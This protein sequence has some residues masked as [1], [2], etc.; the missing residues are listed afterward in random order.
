MKKHNSSE[1]VRKTNKENEIIVDLWDLTS[2]GISNKNIN[3]SNKY[4]IT[5]SITS[6]SNTKQHHQHPIKRTKSVD[7]SNQTKYHSNINTTVPNSNNNNNNNSGIKKQRPCTSLPKHISSKKQSNP[8]SNFNISLSDFNNP[9]N[10]VKYIKHKCID[11]NTNKPRIK[12]YDNF[13]LTNNNDITTKLKP[14]HIRK[15]S[16]EIQTISN[17]LYNKKT[18][19]SNYQLQQKMKKISDNRKQEEELSQCTFKPKLYSN[20]QKRKSTNNDQQLNSNQIYEQQNK[21]LNIINEKKEK[22]FEMKQLKELE[23]CSFNPKT[24]KMPNF[25][26]GNYVNK[27]NVEKELY[28]SKLKRVSQDKMKLNEKEKDFA[29]CYDQRK[30]KE[31]LIKQ[32]NLQ[33]DNVVYSAPQYYKEL[34][35]NTDANS[36]NISSNCSRKEVGFKSSQMSNVNLDSVINSNNNCYNNKISSPY[37]INSNCNVINSSNNNSNQ[38]DYDFE[39][40]KEMLMKDLHDWKNDNEEDE[41]DDFFS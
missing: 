24:T 39:M 5:P 38:I 29:K 30:K 13:P 19:S 8:K 33:K 23:H 1:N 35:P 15:S 27:T 16:Q 6:S 34:Q 9:D 3:K 41:E 11:N 32:N 12:D 31:N 22:K 25:N 37:N 40:K 28:Y 14:K 17:N 10:V 36:N 18:V 7:K 26:K 20:N 21:W 4:T 2:Y